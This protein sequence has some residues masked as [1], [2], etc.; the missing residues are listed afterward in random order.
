MSS[1]T[2]FSALELLC[3]AHCMFLRFT[4]TALSLYLCESNL[5]LFSCVTS[6]VT[7]ALLVHIWLL[8]FALSEI[9]LYSIQKVNN[10]RSSVFT[11]SMSVV[12]AFCC[13]SVS[14]VSDYAS[15]VSAHHIYACR[16]FPKILASV[17]PSFSW[18]VF[19]CHRSWK[20]AK[21]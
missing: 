14:F 18:S 21:C 15:R 19:L 13:T 11:L 9:Q 7:V 5:A 8:I 16:C 12:E 4:F 6:F 17:V 10:A 1:S 2:S 20:F 3:V